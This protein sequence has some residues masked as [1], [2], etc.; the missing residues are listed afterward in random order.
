MSEIDDFDKKLADKFR[1]KL[2]EYEATYNA[3]D[4]KKLQPKLHKSPFTSI[5]R[6]PYW[7]PL[8]VAAGLAL[9][10]ACFWQ[11]STQ[12][13]D[14]QAVVQNT[15]TQK[16]IDSKIKKNDKVAS[17]EIVPIIDS[18]KIKIQ[19]AENEIVVEKNIEN[20]V[21][22]NKA[23]A[24]NQI[25][26]NQKIT[27]SNQS[28]HE[29]TILNAQ[30]Q[31]P[32]VE[33]PPINLDNQKRNPQKNVNSQQENIV[34]TNI[35]SQKQLFVVLPIASDSLV[36][37]YEIP[38]PKGTIDLTVQNLSKETQK[39][40][41]PAISVGLAMNPLLYNNEIE[42]HFAIESGLQLGLALSH[43]VQLTAGF[44][45]ASQKMTYTRDKKVNK[46]FIIAADTSKTT[47]GI[48]NTPQ[49]NTV[50]SSKEMRNNLLIIN[51]PINLQYYFWHG[52]KVRLFAA[53]GVSN[54]AY[55]VE[56]YEFT[57]RVSN[58]AAIDQNNMSFVASRPSLPPNRTNTTYDIT[59]EQSYPS[60]SQLDLFSAVNLSSGI[61][62][63]VSSR[64]SLQVSPFV[65]LPLRKVGHEQIAFNTFGVAVVMS[66]K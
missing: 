31:S 5:W 16:E 50:T 48:T 66:Y 19:N 12:E 57:N 28:S 52:E 47:I 45:L 3:A 65:R 22:K 36:L 39:R 7:K 62:Y 40:G 42:N 59:F 60:F 35:E 34:F 38:K 14:A 26:V 29:K 54:Y 30:T 1:E 18:T 25:S 2:G 56:K 27:K 23:I 49:E 32:K 9:L 43:R 51:M 44:L 6:A 53:I 55:L 13:N 33:L 10:L 61:D 17:S 46:E 63:Q 58:V 24:E 11:F 21:E 4:W 15:P 20:T 64:W 8:A 37:A 41:V